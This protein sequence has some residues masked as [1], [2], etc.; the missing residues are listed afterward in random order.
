MSH[1]TKGS[2]REAFSEFLGTLLLV[3]TSTPLCPWR[4]PG[5]IAPITTWGSGAG[6]VLANVMFE[7][8]TSWSNKDRVDFGT[9][10]AEVVATAGLV[11]V[12]FGLTCG[13]RGHL[14]PGAVPCPP[15]CSPAS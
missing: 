10:V 11:L 6:A 14:V 1:H 12:I 9:L 15:T 8:P 5:S 3:R 2:G 13:G 7:V 4:L